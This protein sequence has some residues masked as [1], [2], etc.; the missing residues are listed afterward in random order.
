M[1]FNLYKKVSHRIGDGV[2]DDTKAIN[3]AI[4]DGN[5]CAPDECGSSTTTPA[6][7]YFPTGNYSV[8]SPIIPYYMTQLIGNPNA[9]PVL[10]ARSTFRG[11][12]VIDAGGRGD[13]TLGWSGTNIFLR[14]I[15]NIDV[16]LTQISPFQ[17]A[18]GIHWPTAQATSLQN[19][20]ITMSPGSVHKGIHIPL[21]QFC[22]YINI[23][24]Y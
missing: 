12:A 21:G 7:V 4:S 8:S 20:I 10:H 17:E 14:Q 13:G 22:Y 2:T 15:R 3:A 1:I 18:V 6:I 23:F 24:Q 9:H 11:F 19:I 16:D 5:R